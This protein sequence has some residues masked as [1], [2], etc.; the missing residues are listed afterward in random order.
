MIGT[1][2]KIIMKGTCEVKKDCCG[3][4]FGKEFHLYEGDKFNYT[5]MKSGKRKIV[6][7][8]HKDINFHEITVR[9]GLFRRCFQINKLQFLYG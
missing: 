7:L 4:L 1:F 9:P 6:V 2:G 5:V 8:K 3:R